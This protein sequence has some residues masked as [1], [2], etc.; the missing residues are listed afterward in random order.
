MCHSN[1]RYPLTNGSVWDFYSTQESAAATAVL[2]RVTHNGAAAAASAWG[3][4][5]R[6]RRLDTS[7]LIRTMAKSVVLIAPPYNREGNKRKMRL[8]TGEVSIKDVHVVLLR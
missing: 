8:R 4:M 2:A 7:P 5:V 1:L 6:R 3:P